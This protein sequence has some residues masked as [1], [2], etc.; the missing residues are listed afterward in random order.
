M[1]NRGRGMLHSLFSPG[2]WDFIHFHLR[3]K[4]VLRWSPNGVGCGGFKW[5]V[6]YQHRDLHNKLT[7]FN[8]PR[9]S[10]LS[11]TLTCVANDSFRS[12]ERVND[13]GKTGK[14]NGE[15]VM[16]LARALI[17]SLGSLRSHDGTANERSLQNRTLRSVKFFAIILCWSRCTNYARFTIVCLERMQKYETF[18]AVHVGSHCRQNLIKF[19]FVKNCTKKRAARLFCLI[20]PIKSLVFCFDVVIS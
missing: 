1:K 17:Q 16:R 12:S 7:S 6:H 20:Q 9:K 18:P 2:T 11:S 5:P 14:I 3:K 13:R 15:V 4:W 8:W 10:K 19:H